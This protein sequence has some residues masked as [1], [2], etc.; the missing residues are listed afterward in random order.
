ML[1]SYFAHTVELSRQNRLTNKYKNLIATEIKYY[2]NGSLIGER[3]MIKAFKWLLIIL[4][5]NKN[6]MVNISAH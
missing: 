4:R 6:F 2:L 1:V 5:Y 3:K